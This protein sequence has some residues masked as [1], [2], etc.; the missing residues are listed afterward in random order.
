MERPKEQSFRRSQ[1][2]KAVVEDVYSE[3][4]GDDHEQKKTPTVY[5][6]SKMNLF[7][8]LRDDEG[9]DRKE[10]I[11]EDIRNYIKRNSKYLVFRVIAHEDLSFSY[12][13]SDYYITVLVKYRRKIVREYFYFF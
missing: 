4:D 12:W 10:E 7:I 5:G 11:I 2:G 3:N 9:L 6:P 1:T 13:L 8:P